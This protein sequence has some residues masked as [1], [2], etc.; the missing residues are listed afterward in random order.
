[1]LRDEAAASGS[2]DEVA[3]GGRGAAAERPE[4]SGILSRVRFEE[5]PVFRVE[6]AAA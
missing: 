6:E 1:M 3:G 5:R 4:R 2:M